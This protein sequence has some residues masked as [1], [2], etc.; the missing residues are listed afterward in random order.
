MAED[1][2]QIIKIDTSPASLSIKD[3][4][5]NIKLLKESLDEKNIGTP[6]YKAAL[7]ELQLNQN[8]LKDAM[9]A[10]SASMDQVVESAKGAGTSYNSLVHRMAELKQELRATDVSTESGKKKFK[11]LAAEVNNVNDKLKDMD[12]L[13]GNF[14]RNV[15]DYPGLM[16]NFAGAMDSLDKGLKV[17]EGGVM[18]LKGGFDALAA[19]PIIAIVGLIIT[20]FSK[21]AGKIKE[22]ESA[23]EA[24]KRGMDAL[25]PVFDMVAKVIEKLAGWVAKVIDYIVDLA[26]KNKDTF[27]NMIAAVVGV[28]N[29][30][31]QVLLLPIKNTIAAVKGL[32][33]AFKHLF[34]GEFKEAAASAKETFSQ[35]GDQFKS[36]FDFKGNFEKGKEV[37]EQFAA[38]LGSTKKKVSETAKSVGKEAKDSLLDGLSDISDDID[39][40][41][42]AEMAAWEKAQEE[43]LKSAK[44]SEENRLQAMEKAVKQVLELNDIM[45]DDER[46]KAVKQYAIQEAANQKR[47]QALQQFAKDALERGDLDAYLEYDQQAADLEVEIQN[48]A[49]KEKKRL[50]ELDNQ[51][52]KE[53]A[54][55]QMEIMQSVASATSGILSSIA[56]MYENDSENAEKNAKKIKALRISAATIDTI[57]GAIGA[58][59]QAAE[60]IPP[61]A[62]I[63]VG[64]IQAA[65]VTAA[66]LAQIA[67]IKNTEV[68]AS[69]SGSASGN[70]SAISAAP[71]LTTEV[72]NVRSIT[73]AS[74]EER[75]N[76]MAS[77]Q[78]V[79]ILS[80]DIEASQKAIKT[81]VAEASF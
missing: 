65:A 31:L 29:A 17:T 76:Q 14:Q 36:A 42:D 51:D 45:V 38:G 7:K 5:N 57:S 24:L 13:Q 79:Y 80:S 9:Y 1:I 40:L 52:A 72:A 26:E 71:T 32:G 66:G 43:A 56:D 11:E 28:G 81:Q 61:P 12:A 50:R 20:L 47:L 44:A 39:K 25:Q 27:K 63:I 16:K 15:G 3:L 22:N 37:G 74:E 53:K 4:R 46:E 10:T 69:E 18:G 60:T 77:E 30:I 8:A 21:L 67:Q 62:G 58:F 6:E 54:K 59:T 19:N 55:Q 64:A 35:I 33:D 2:I 41:M 73:S 34:K 48:N 49:L 78:R 75:L 23:T 70:I 68:S